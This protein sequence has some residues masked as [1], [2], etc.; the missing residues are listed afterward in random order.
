[1]DMFPY[2]EHKRNELLNSDVRFFSEH[3]NF[4]LN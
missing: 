2:D 4:I 3:F 1:M